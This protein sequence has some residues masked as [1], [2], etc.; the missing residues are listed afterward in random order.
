M[1][2]YEVL[3]TLC[4]AALQ[5]HEESRDRALEFL[6]SCFLPGMVRYLDCPA[7][8]VWIFDFHGSRYEDVTLRTVLQTDDELYWNIG[9]VVR[10]DGSSRFLDFEY[11][12]R[13][14]ENDG[15]F[16]VDIAGR[17]FIIEDNHSLDACYAHIV[18]H[19]SDQM[20]RGLTDRNRAGVP[21]RVELSPCNP[22]PERFYGQVWYDVGSRALAGPLQ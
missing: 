18:L 13:C 4:E 20:K 19:M 15:T 17:K 22:G 10:I 16:N 9:I 12:F 2:D 1:S 5:N 6:G 21:W 14:Q 8:H 7:E 11:L 3:C